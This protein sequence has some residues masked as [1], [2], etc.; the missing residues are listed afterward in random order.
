LKA[1]QGE[2][3]FLEKSLIYVAKQPAVVEFQDI[4]QVVFSRYISMPSAVLSLLNA[5]ILNRVGGQMA[6]AR[7][8]DLNVQPK[9]GPELTF[10]S[11]IKEEHEQIENYL[12]AKK[13]RVKNE[14]LDDMM[15]GVAAA[16]ESDS[17]EEMASAASTD[18][19]DQPKKVKGISMDDDED[20]E[21][22][23]WYEW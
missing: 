15:I 18:E 4:H 22:G 5:D 11:I 19:E 13:V 10:T 14:M 17:D 12:K 1:V 20:S 7:T 3:Y 2:L 16:L 6:V 8:F 9:S 21:E 23:S